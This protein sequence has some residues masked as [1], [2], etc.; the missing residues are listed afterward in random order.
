MHQKE[1]EV[2][3]RASGYENGDRFHSEEEVRN[4]FSRSNFHHMFG[5]CDETDESLS[6]MAEH[7]IKTRDNC[8]F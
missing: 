1:L 8:D 7:V 6:E 4:Y 5:Y 3:L 2:G